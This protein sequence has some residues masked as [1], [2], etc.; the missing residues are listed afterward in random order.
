[1]AVTKSRQ[2]RIT[3]GS[4]LGQCIKDLAATVQTNLSCRALRYI[5]FEAL[6]PPLGDPCFV[7]SL[8]AT[9]ALRDRAD[10]TPLPTNER[11]LFTIA[12]PRRVSKRH[13][14]A[15]K[16]Y[17]LRHEANRQRRGTKVTANIRHTPIV[18]SE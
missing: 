1:M 11:D 2:R 7:H 16:G 5:I 14:A 13:I 10:A 15:S 3:C 18:A 17:R 8:A 9:T 12:P 6:R 4:R